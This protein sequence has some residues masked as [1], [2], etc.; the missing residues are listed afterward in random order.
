MEKTEKGINGLTLKFIA[1]ITMLLDHMYYTVISGSLW[2][3]VVGRASF[4][5][6]AFL[7]VEGFF[8]T[9]SVKK[10][11]FRLLIFALISEIPFNLMMSGSLI[12]PFDQNTIW[13][14]L[15]G[16]LVIWAIDKPF[17][18]LVNSKDLT[19]R[20]KNMVRFVLVGFAAITVGC[21]AALIGMTDYH[22]VGVLTVV[23]FYLC[24]GKPFWQLVA[25]LL[26]NNMLGGQELVFTLFGMEQTFKIQL[27]AALA[28]IPIS[29]YNGEKGYGSRAMQYAF[30]AFYPLHMLLL[31][32]LYMY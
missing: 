28:M 25:L 23:M 12:F 29:L 15:I 24:R 8:H 7:I 16:L 22:Y 32:L 18:A 31:A 5:I 27:A 30:Y 6:F 3:T 14:L 9:K 4:P 11:A 19:E 13:T 26:I 10:Y 20:S 17:K 1:V 2:M 21:L